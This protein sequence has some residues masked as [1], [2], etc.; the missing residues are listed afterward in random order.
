MHGLWCRI[1]AIGFM[2]WGLGMG[3]ALRFALSTRRSLFCSLTCARWGVK[4]LMTA[5]ECEI[6]LE[7]LV[8]PR[9]DVTV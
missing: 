6:P 7:P 3:D 1:E 8:I 5:S 4:G 2:G 9:V